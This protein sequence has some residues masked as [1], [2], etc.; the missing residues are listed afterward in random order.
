MDICL[1]CNGAILEPNKPYRYAGSVCL[2]P[3][4][5]SQLY[6]RQSNTSAWTPGLFNSNNSLSQIKIDDNR[7][8][9]NPKLQVKFKKLHDKVKSPCYAKSG[10][11]AMDLTAISKTRDKENITY[12]TGLAFEIP[13]GYVGLLFPRSSLTNYNLLLGNHVGVIDSGYRGE[14]T[15][16]FK[17]TYN[18]DIPKEY[19]VGDRVGQLLIIPYPQ[20]ELVEA[21][22]LSSSE[23]GQNGYGSTGQ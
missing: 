19:E 20:I 23:R 5:P 13:T 15:F 3:K 18:Y 11:A 10:D 9:I 2:C 7:V 1:N 16:K 22:E 12:G 17:Y 14:I 6:Q 4:D 8:S 21:D